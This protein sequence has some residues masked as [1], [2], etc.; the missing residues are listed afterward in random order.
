MVVPGHPCAG[1]TTFGQVQTQ[2]AQKLAEIG[3][4][5]TGENKD[6]IQ[7]IQSSANQLLSNLTGWLNKRKEEDPKP[8]QKKSSH[9]ISD[10]EFIDVQL[11]DKQH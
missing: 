4:N 9:D 1:T 11:E 7:N 3:K 5:I 6:Q 8:V 10:S 2:F